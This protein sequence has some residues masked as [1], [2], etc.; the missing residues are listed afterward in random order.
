MGLADSPLRD[1]M[2]FIEGA[3]RSG[4]TWLITLLA[5]HPDIAGVQAES[6]LF[7]YGV[8]CLFDNFEHRDPRLHGLDSFV[9][10]DELVDIARQVCDS[11]FT[12]MRNHVS[13]AS[14]PRFVV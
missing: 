7:D 14:T 3:P 12:A 1:R 6:H 5:T 9:D 2:I 11:V 8:D 13:G 4:T 10:R